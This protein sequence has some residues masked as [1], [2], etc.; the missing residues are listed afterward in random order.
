MMFACVLV[1]DDEPTIASNVCKYLRRLGCE[2]HTAHSASEALNRFEAIRP[3]LVLLDFWLPDGDGLELLQT[4]LGRDPAVN[5]IMV[6]GQDRIETAVQ[7]L[8]SGARDY[9]TKPLSLAQ[10]KLS[11]ERLAAQERLQ[12]RESFRNRQLAADNAIAA[13][14]GESEPMRALRAAVSR[15]VKSVPGL[16]SGEQPSVLISGETGT[17]KGL[18]ARALHFGEAGNAAPFIELNCAAIPSQLLESELFGH[19]RG[20]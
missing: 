10:L 11:M 1:V 3:E 2:A 8:K 7:A 6:S 5:V 9:L 19:E 17:G 13:L 16:S 15:I 20:A 14:Q 12:A 4:L 18:I